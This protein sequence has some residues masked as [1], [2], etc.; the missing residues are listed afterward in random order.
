MEEESISRGVCGFVLHV[1]FSEECIRH[2][3]AWKAGHLA[4]LHSCGW[5][6]G[7]V[8][9]IEW[10]HLA[11]WRLVG[12]RFEDGKKG[13][14]LTWVSTLDFRKYPDSFQ[15]MVWGLF[16]TEIQA[17]FIFRKWQLGFPHASVSW[18]QPLHGGGSLWP[19]KRAVTKARFRCERTGCSSNTSQ[20]QMASARCPPLR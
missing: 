20:V 2:I 12:P 10:C 3:Q 13:K 19:G 18:S 15:E 4:S 5:R 6:K 7:F 17:L 8:R 9:V 1:K 11:F 16:H 14:S